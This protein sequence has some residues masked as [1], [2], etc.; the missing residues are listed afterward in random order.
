MLSLA[1]S[2]VAWRPVRYSQ[3]IR[4]FCRFLYLFLHSCCKYPAWQVASVPP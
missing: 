4:I 3:A 1:G 2:G